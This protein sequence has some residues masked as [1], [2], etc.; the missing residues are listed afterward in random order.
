MRI[1]PSSAKRILKS[2]KLSKRYNSGGELE[3]YPS[4]S[5]K[6]K[7]KRAS[8]KSDLRHKGKN[9]YVFEDCS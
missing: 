7:E 5:K 8:K 9:V 6:P 3:L 4:V 2:L 1:T